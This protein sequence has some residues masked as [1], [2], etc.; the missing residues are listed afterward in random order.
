MSRIKVT[1]D[2]EIE[3]LSREKTVLRVT[4]TSVDGTQHKVEVMNPLG[5]PDNPMQD[6]H[7]EEKFCAL[8]EPALGKDRCRTALDRWWRIANADD[9]SE[10]IQL[11]DL[12]PSSRRLP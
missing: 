1:V 12:E 4:A 11:L 5:H 6:S 10:L 2:D 7:I 3:S 8:A 9:M